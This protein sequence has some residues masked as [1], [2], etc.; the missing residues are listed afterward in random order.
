MNID[1]YNLDS[2]RA[3][4]RKLEKENKNL[5]QKLNEA[6]IPYNSENIFVESSEENAEYDLDQGGRIMERYITENMA[7]WYFSMFWGRDDVYAKRGSKGGY[8]PQ[9]NNRWN[10]RLCPK[11]K[12]IKMACEACEHKEWAKLTLDKIVAHL[13]GYKED[14]SDVLG[15]YPLLP[16]GTCRFLVFDFD[17]HEKGAQ[18][19]DFANTDNEWQDEVNALRRMCEINGIKPLVERS[20]SGRGAHVWIFFKKPIPASMVRNFGFMLLDKGSASVNMKS[21]HYYDRMYPSQDVASSIGN[22][23]ALPLQGRALK[24]GNSAF[25]DENWNAY[26]DQWD[27]LL[28][29]TRK[30]ELEEIGQYMKNWKSEMFS[31]SVD[32]SVDIFENRPKPWKKR[33]NFSVG[34]VTSK[35][36]IV[37]GDGVYIDTLNLTPKIQNQIRSMAAFD[38]PLYYKNKRMGYSNYYNF[39]AV[40]MGK[41]EN[42][43]ICIPRGLKEKVIAECENAGIE[44]DIED[45]REKGRPIR[46]AFNGDLRIQQDLAA[47]RMLAYDNGILSAATA[48]GKTV[49]CSYL[50]A[51]RKVNTLILL[52]S[53]DLLE[54]WVE[55]LNHFLVID[56]EPPVYTTKTGRIKKR[57]SVIGVLHGGKN[58]L[59]GIVDVAMVGS[60]YSKGKF[61]ELL[62]TYGMVI[63]DECHHAASNTA[64]EV[65]QKV[66]ARYVY[67]VSATIKRDD[68]LEKIIYMLL[69]PVRHKFTA[70]ERA[71]EQGI[72]HLVYPRYTRIVDTLESKKDV[73]KAFDI[74][75][76]SSLRNEQIE[77]DIQECISN[78]R[79]PVI[80]T[81]YKEQAKILYENLQNTADYVFLLYGNNTDKV[82]KEIREK[83]KLV[84]RDK[85]M[86]LIATGQKIGE[87]F[88]CPRLDTL[89]LAAPVSF[90][91]RLEQYVGRLNRDYPEKKDVI[92]YDYVDSHMYYFNKMYTKRL[93]TYKKMGFDIISGNQKEKQT[94]NAIYSADNYT[95]IF[96]RDLA[97]ANNS[98]II[99][100]PTITA[101]KIERFIQ[102]LKPRQEA[103]VKVSVILTNPE[104]RYYGNADF[105]LN[106]IEKM[107]E[108]GIQVIMLDEDTECFAIIDQELVWHG[109]M[110]LLGKVDAWDN[111]IRIKSE[112]IAQ[113]LMGMI[114]KEFC[115]NDVT[116]SPSTL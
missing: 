106:L 78:G 42:G 56:E 21:F 70:K 33:E 114:P 5:K 27:I 17:N 53:K 58:S 74:I 69:G 24:K 47:Q 105:Y 113:E 50:I 19:T 61:N 25:V 40:Y 13:V 43:Y 46:V 102:I 96:E 48:F 108:I 84:P 83:I 59:T 35:L 29:H 92:V 94:V 1:A 10:D 73:N 26:P 116:S 39:S 49:V 34:D 109:G 41:D 36:H 44:Y 8:F 75:C 4:V 104:N 107:K 45:C 79:T 100:S 97:E 62:N 28:N 81:R 31:S 52:Q 112:S 16:D 72:L 80:L 14:G 110:N 23:I 68:N 3:L 11:Q 57:N 54:Q 115:D 12:K 95:D 85:S 101:E 65:L 18:E 89:M 111:L 82:N 86:I 66:N 90:P 2:L 6:N 15:M 60:V 22:L 103:G 98:I 64:V 71:M 77:A 30:L 63:M 67:G 20:R 55:E 76:K 51:E 88:D 91:G 87:G 38:N 37:L 93:R 7:K 99:S 32:G 9:C